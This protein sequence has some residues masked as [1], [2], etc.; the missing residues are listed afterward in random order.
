MH[1]SGEMS[2]TFES[3]QLAALEVE[4][5]VHVVDSGQ[6]GIATGYAA[7]TAADVLDAGGT[8]EEAALAALARGRG[9]H[10]AV[11]RRHAGVPPPRR[12]DRRRRRASSA[13]RCR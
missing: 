5:P 13:A 9:G 8:G 12:P 2:G 10:L 6:V 4:L 3:A 1:L 11:L 7:L